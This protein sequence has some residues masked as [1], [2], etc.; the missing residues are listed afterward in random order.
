M[1]HSVIGID[2]S[3]ARVRE[4]A[5]S[6]RP[7]ATGAD[8][9]TVVEGGGDAAERI[10]ALGAE[11]AEQDERHR[12]PRPPKRSVPRWLVRVRYLGLA[13]F[14]G[15]MIYAGVERNPRVFIAGLVGFTIWLGLVSRG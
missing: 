15:Q 2:A 4:A 9:V 11:I 14:A 8:A 10:R 5:P 13:V 3:K 6:L 1:A 7:K 12:P